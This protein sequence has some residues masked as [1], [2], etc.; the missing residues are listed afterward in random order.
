MKRIII[1]EDDG[2]PGI[3][4][5]PYQGI[6]DLAH[7]TYYDPCYNCSNNPKNN[8]AAS[9]VCC[10]SLPDMYNHGYP[11]TTAPKQYYT[12]TTTATIDNISDNTGVINC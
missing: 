11:I 8:P 5:S 4:V 10:C 9:G 3:N 6:Y 7:P 1:I 2:L 12:A